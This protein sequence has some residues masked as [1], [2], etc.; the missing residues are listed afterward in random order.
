MNRMLSDSRRFMRD[1]TGWATNSGTREEIKTASGWTVRW[2]E[3]ITAFITMKVGR[4]AIDWDLERRIRAQSDF[5]YEGP[6][7]LERPR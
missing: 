1:L 5:V 7:S 3:V 2:A 6:F 4:D